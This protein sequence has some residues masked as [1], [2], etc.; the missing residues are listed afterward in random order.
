VNLWLYVVLPAAIG[1][2]VGF[3]VALVVWCVFRRL[4]GEA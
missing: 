1:G 3:V 2:V 4:Y